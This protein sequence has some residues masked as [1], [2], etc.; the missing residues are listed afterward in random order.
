MASKPAPYSRVFVDR[1][2]GLLRVLVGM[3]GL[4]AILVLIGLASILSRLTNEAAVGQASPS[5]IAGNAATPGVATRDEPLSE[6][7]VAPDA[8]K[9]SVAAQPVSRR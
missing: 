4:V 1:N 2:E 5:A 7:G 6:I 3:A 9:A 8:P